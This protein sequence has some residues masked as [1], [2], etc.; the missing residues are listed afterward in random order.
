MKHPPTQSLT[1]L[2]PLPPPPVSRAH[3]ESRLLSTPVAVCVSLLFG[4]LVLVMFSPRTSSGQQGAQIGSALRTGA[5]TICFTID[6]A[7]GMTA[8]QRLAAVAAE[9]SALEAGGVQGITKAAAIL[10]AAAG[11]LPIP[12]DCTPVAAQPPPPPAPKPKSGHD[13]YLQNTASR[14]HAINHG[15]QLDDAPG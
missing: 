3:S 2:R 4:V 1:S 8:K 12:H 15:K 7:T 9:V 13:I 14:T 6:P 11:G 5:N 10:H